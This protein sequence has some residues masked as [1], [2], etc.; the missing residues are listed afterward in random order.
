MSSR[1]EVLLR[2]NIKDV[3][4]C[5]DVVKVTAGY[6]RNYLLPRKL[7]ITAND[8][9]K[10][11]MMRRRAILDVEEAQRTAEIQARVATLDGIMVATKVKADEN[12]HLYGSVNAGT[13]VELLERT[14]HKY[15][16][17]AIRLDA[18]I[19][20]VGTHAVKIHVQGDH[21][22]EVKVVVEAETE[23]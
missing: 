2:E 6:A 16:E 1:V 7:A 9:N 11:A 21:Y 4:R 18:P 15:E 19:K 12:G 13:I 23:G 17:K 5:G 3:G 22:A 8:E 20:T 14:G 10:K